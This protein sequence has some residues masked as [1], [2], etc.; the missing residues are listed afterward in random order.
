MQFREYTTTVSITDDQ[1][2]ITSKFASSQVSDVVT[3][4]GSED[5]NFAAIANAHKAIALDAGPVAT[6]PR[7]TV[8]T[9]GR[10][11]KAY[12]GGSFVTP[13]TVLNVPVGNSGHIILRRDA[14]SFTMTK[15]PNGGSFAS[16]D[17]EDEITV[18]DGDTLAFGVSSLDEQEQAYG[19]VIDKDTG[20][21]IDY[22]QLLN[23]TPAP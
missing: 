10:W 8:L 9:P 17:D 16:F 6:S 3:R 18:V 23:T 13:S 14:G 20:N 2:T 15:S 12:L 4:D 11:N 5:T 1:I 19:Y 22:I 21:I 7:I